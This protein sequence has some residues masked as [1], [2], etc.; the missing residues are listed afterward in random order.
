MRTHTQPSR[1][2]SCLISH[3]LEVRWHA[4]ADMDKPLQLS[5]I[6]GEVPS[7]QMFGAPDKDDPFGSKE[8]DKR[9]PEVTKLYGDWQTEEWIP[10]QAENGVV[11]KND[12]G[13]VLCPPLA[14]CL[15]QVCGHSC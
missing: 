1:A 5:E 2:L 8:R 4:P 11:P 15:P 10:P 7:L 6:A 12:R 3:T 14:Y 13:N 9:T